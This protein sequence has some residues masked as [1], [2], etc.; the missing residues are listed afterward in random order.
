MSS[1][2]LGQSSSG[3]VTVT[4]PS[5]DLV[6]WR[7][8]LQPSFFSLPLSSGL[9]KPAQ[10]VTVAVLYKPAALGSHQASLTISS[11]VVRGGQETPGTATSNTVLLQA[12][13]GRPETPVSKAAKSGGTVRLERDLIVFSNTKVGEV[14][15][16]KVRL[17]IISLLLSLYSDHF[18][19][20]RS[21]LRTGVVLIAS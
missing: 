12:K 5:Q 19:L 9:L 3:E 6:Q 1:P 11:Q 4:N 21:R 8:I 16:A 18:C 7:A 15:I 2:R 17:R 13:C 20:C 10:S 14:S